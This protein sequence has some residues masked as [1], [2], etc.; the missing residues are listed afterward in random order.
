[1]TEAPFLRH[2]LRRLWSTSRSP[3]SVVLTGHPYAEADN[4]HSHIVIHLDGF[5]VETK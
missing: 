4:R 2:A 3:R 1:M 5:A